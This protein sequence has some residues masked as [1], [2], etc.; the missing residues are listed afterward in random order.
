MSCSIVVVLACRRS[1]FIFPIGST[2]PRGIEGVVQPGGGPCPSPPVQPPPSLGGQ[3][4]AS[5]APRQSA[6]RAGES[7]INYRHHTLQSVFEQGC[8]ARVSQRAP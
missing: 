7:I 8:D 5:P 2:T 6:L 3:R 1:T 4:P